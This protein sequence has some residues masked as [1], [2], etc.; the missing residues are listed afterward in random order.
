M[1]NKFWE[2]TVFSG[3]ISL[4]LRAAQYFFPPALP[5]SYSPKSYSSTSVVTASALTASLITSKR[6]YR[7]RRS[8]S[9]AK[10][11]NVPNNSATNLSG[12]LSKKTL[13]K[14]SSVPTASSSY[15]FTYKIKTKTKSMSAVA[16]PNVTTCQ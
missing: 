10:Y 14:A 3:R 11:R 9:S 12:L 2:A 5:A 1:R 4:K 7:E 6:Q 16:S 13:L 8:I 15:L